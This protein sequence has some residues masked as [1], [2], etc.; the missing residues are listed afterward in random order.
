M[1]VVDNRRLIEMKR[2]PALDESS[3]DSQQPMK[4][5]LYVGPSRREEAAGADT[6]FTRDEQREEARKVAERIYG[7]GA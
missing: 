4:L 2:S 6:Q 3:E 7:K 5:F 1:D